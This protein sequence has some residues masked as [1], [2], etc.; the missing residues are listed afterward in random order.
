MCVEIDMDHN[1]RRE[2]SRRNWIKLV[3]TL[4]TAQYPLSLLTTAM[5]LVRLLKW[6]RRMK[7]K[8]S[9]LF[10]RVLL[11]R[12]TTQLLCSGL[13]FTKSKNVHNFIY[14]TWGYTRAHMNGP[15]EKQDI[16]IEKIPKSFWQNCTKLHTM[17]CSFVLSWHFLF[18]CFMI[19]SNCKANKGF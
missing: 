13:I 5:L 2:T 4:L 15:F 11:N 12:D 10:C 19:T 8:V 9:W 6:R 3:N 16:P 7:H 1:P 14:C 18:V 17:W